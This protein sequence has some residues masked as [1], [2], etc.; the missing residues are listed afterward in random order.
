MMLIF[1]RL[2]GGVSRAYDAAPRHLAV[3]LEAGGRGREKVLS[4]SSGCRQ[5]RAV[6][7]ASPIHTTYMDPL[8]SNHGLPDYIASLGVSVVTERLPVMI[9]SR[10]N[11]KLRVVNQ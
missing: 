9:R 4:E 3:E 2:W 11:G 5:R 1:P 6:L 7:I 8:K 10:L